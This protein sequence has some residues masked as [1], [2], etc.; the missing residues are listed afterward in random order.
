MEKLRCSECGYVNSKKEHRVLH[1]N[2][3]TILCTL[4][5]KDLKKKREEMN[6]KRKRSKVPIV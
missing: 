2:S 6:K 3:E 5:H 1:I 4:C